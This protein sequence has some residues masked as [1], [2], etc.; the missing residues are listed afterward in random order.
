MFAIRHLR[1]N[2]PIAMSF[3]AGLVA[4]SAGAQCDPSWNAVGT[5]M[6]HTVQAVVALPN[7]D[8][9]AGGGFTSV[10]VVSANYIARWN[11]TTREWSPIG[12]GMESW[13]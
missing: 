13:V 10:G 2:R 12:K 4:A 9:I 5:G 7:G 8:L 3:A 6:D 11:A 1:L